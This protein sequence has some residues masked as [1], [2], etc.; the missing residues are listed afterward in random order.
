M[1]KFHKEEYGV[2]KHFALLVSIVLVLSVSATIVFAASN[3]N[4][5]QAAVDRE[6]IPASNSI[7]NIP[8][9]INSVGVGQEYDLSALE[10]WFEDLQIKTEQLIADDKLTQEQAEEIEACA[11]GVLLGHAHDRRVQRRCVQ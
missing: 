10:K 2:R 8:T 1:K 6:D 5:K 9:D 3:T 7:S 4:N 11:L